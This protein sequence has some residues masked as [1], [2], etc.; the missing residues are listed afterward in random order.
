MDA[1][2]FV[3][4]SAITASAALAAL[5]HKPGSL[6]PRQIRLF[7]SPKLRYGVAELNKGLAAYNKAFA[8]MESAAA[9]VILPFQIS[10]Q[11]EGNTATAWSHHD[12]MLSNTSFKGLRGMPSSSEE[13]RLLLT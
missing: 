11:E 2:P 10:G 7:L 12:T 5:S 4:A 13:A 6:L 3:S 1:P 8:F 9:F